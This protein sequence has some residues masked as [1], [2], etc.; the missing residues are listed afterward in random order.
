MFVNCDVRRDAQGCAARTH[1]IAQLKKHNLV[2]SR[3]ELDGGTVL[4]SSGFAERSN[5]R[6][7][8]RASMAPE[9]SPI[10]FACSKLSWNDFFASPYF[11]PI[12]SARQTRS[13][14][15][16]VWYMRTSSNAPKLNNTA[17]S[18]C[19]Q[20]AMPS[21]SVAAPRI[22]RVFSMTSCA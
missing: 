19:S 20:R 12:Y 7:A 10:R 18:V 13:Q 8:L 2:T 14:R 3:Q 9:R 6:S 15:L 17:A 1:N 5:R 21:A 4:G 22:V 16:N 11:P